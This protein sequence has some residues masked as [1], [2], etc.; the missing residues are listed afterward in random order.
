M[1]VLANMTE[2]GKTPLFTTDE[3]AK[4]GV[5]MVLYPLSA[6]RAMSAV[7]QNVYQHIRREGTQSNVVPTMQTRAELYEVLGYLD[8]EKQLDKLFDNKGEDDE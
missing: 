5:D 8:Y 6:F 1:P 7:A 2:F 3:L 4:A